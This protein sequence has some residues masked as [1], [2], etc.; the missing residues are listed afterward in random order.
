MPTKRSLTTSLRS[1]PKRVNA[2]KSKTKAN[3]SRT[4]LSRVPRSVGFPKQLRVKHRY[5]EGVNLVSTSGSL[6]LQ[7]FRCNGLFDPNQTGG[8]HQPMYYDN[9][10]PL[11]NH[12]VVMASKI[13]VHFAAVFNSNP[14]ACVGIFI[15][16]DTT[17]TPANYEACAEQST[18]SYTLM[19]GASDEIV[20]RSKSW[21]AS[22]N[23]GGSILANTT[24]QGTDGADPSEQQFYTIWHAPFGAESG[25]VACLVTIEYD[26]V[27]R[28]LK[29]LNSN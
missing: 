8:G 24:L 5:V 11:Y 13:T 1:E 16:N 6:A 28:E 18:A 3:L 14:V 17:T 9:L 25:T 12:Y 29:D 20:T 23:W 10:T 22:E 27:W 21:S 26:C 19:A 2:P 15:N 4:T 7:N